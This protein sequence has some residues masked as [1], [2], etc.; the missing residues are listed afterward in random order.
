M[1]GISNNSHTGFVFPF[2]NA[3][4]SGTSDLPECCFRLIHFIEKRLY[5]RM[6]ICSKRFRYISCWFADYGEVIVRWHYDTWLS[7]HC[8]PKLQV[9]I[10]HV[11][12]SNVRD[13]EDPAFR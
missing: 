7:S 13:S 3:S 5:L 12:R 2:R 6:P 11:T 10:I 8:P 1:R 9:W 4:W